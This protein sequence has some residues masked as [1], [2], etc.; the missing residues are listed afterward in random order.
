MK[1]LTSILALAVAVSASGPA[2]AHGRL[3]TSTPAEGAAVGP[4]PA[5]MS[6]R[7]SEPVEAAMSRV[8]LI[9]PGDKEVTLARAHAD[10]D[11]ARTIAVA[12]PKLDPGAYRAQWTTAGHD[13]HRVKGEIHFTVR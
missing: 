8:K 2:L 10:K 3:E 6:F 4:S 13:G 9:G 7:F 11:D 5:E 12:L 1:H